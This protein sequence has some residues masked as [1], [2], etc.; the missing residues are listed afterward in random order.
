MA[1][2]IAG[3]WSNAQES[4]RVRRA[5]RAVVAAKAGR[6]RLGVFLSSDDAGLVW[7]HWKQRTPDHL[8]S[9]QTTDRSRWISGRGITGAMQHILLRVV[10][11]LLTPGWLLGRA[12]AEGF[13]LAVASADGGCVLL[14][15]GRGLVARQVGWGPLP[16]V[17]YELH[18]RFSRHVP[19]PQRSALSGDGWMEERFVAG[20]S[21]RSAPV[22]TQIEAARVLFDAYTS[23]TRAAARD[24]AGPHLQWLASSELA[25]RLPSEVR[26]DLA[27]LCELPP[28]KGWLLTPSAA[29]VH[30]RN[31]IL[32]HQGGPVLIDYWPFELRP[33]FY[34]PVC[35]AGRL[36]REMR[37]LRDAYLAGVLDE[38]LVGLFEAAGVRLDPTVEARRALLAVALVLRA[39]REIGIAGDRHAH[40]ST[41]ARRPLTPE[42]F[43]RLA[44]DPAFVPKVVELWRA[45]SLGDRS[46]ATG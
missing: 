8:A 19:T 2:R 6:L 30:P 18:A 28:P 15:P 37:S 1:N 3:L 21:L 31:L 23:L 12:G 26:S 45:S 9:Q 34:D 46:G 14:D 36:P 11:W 41:V 43:A 22:A 25:N 39:V 5:G 4:A 44:G 10:S 7:R 40:E 13:P 42:E 16:D 29:D 33:F 32:T 17:Q 38:E 27:G 24:T 35:F 20:M